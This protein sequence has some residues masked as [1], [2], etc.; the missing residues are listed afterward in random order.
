MML[1]KTQAR[2]LTSSPRNIPLYVPD[3]KIDLIDVAM[4][5]SCLRTMR[6]MD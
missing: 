6:S 3:D 4:K 2:G 1:V 5:G